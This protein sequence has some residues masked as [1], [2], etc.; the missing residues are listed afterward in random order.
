MSESSCG[1]ATA[2]TLN[3]FA[4]Y[5]DI[6]GPWLIKNNPFTGFSIKNGI[7]ETYSKTGIGVEP[8]NGFFTNE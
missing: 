7:F 4:D 8:E 5:L 3:S 2:Y 6:D 1:C